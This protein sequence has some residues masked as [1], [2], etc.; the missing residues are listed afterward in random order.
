MMDKVVVFIL[1]YYY[2]IKFY[3]IED[4]IMHTYMN[5]K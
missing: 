4:F 3:I 2:K 5:K 1:L